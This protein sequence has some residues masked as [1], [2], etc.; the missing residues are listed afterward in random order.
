VNSDERKGEKRG[1]GSTRQSRL[2]LTRNQLQLIP[3]GFT[4]SF[5]QIIY[6]QPRALK[7]LHELLVAPRRLPLRRWSLCL[8]LLHRLL[9]WQ[10]PSIGEHL[11]HYIIE[12]DGLPLV[13][14]LACSCSGWIWRVGCSCSPNSWPFAVMSGEGGSGSRRGWRWSVREVAR[15][16]SYP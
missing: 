7:F 5:R 1:A 11:C 6:T 13:L 3:V 9:L 16:G 8:L 2:P 10:I 4:K 14:L 12:I 15:M